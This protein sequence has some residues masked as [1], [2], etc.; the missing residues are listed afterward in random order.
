MKFWK[1]NVNE[2][3]PS[4]METIVVRAEKENDARLLAAGCDWR[5]PDQWID[6]S[7]SSCEELCDEGI[8]EVLFLVYD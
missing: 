3:K 7:K 5:N 2:P 8:P 6:E 1:L 4:Q